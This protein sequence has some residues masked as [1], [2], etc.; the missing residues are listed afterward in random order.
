MI[1]EFSLR[2]E[3]KIVSARGIL[4]NM[5]TY[6]PGNRLD[7]IKNALPAFQKSSLKGKGPTITVGM[8]AVARPEI[9][10]VRVTYGSGFR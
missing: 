10:R 3:D 8:S 2:N 6:A 9:G 7:N 1:S 5:L 4:R